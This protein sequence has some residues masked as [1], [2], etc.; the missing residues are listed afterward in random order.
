[1]L[2]L[3]RFMR[4]SLVAANAGYCLVV[5]LGLLFVVAYLVEHELQTHRL[6]WLWHLGLVAPWHGGSSQTRDQTPPPCTGRWICRWI[7]TEPPG[8]PC[9]CSVT[10]SYLTVWDPM[11]CSTPGFP[12][13]HQLLE[14]T[15]THVH[16]VGDA[17]QPSHSLLPASPPAFIL[18]QHQS[19]FHE[20][21][22]IRV[23]FHESSGSFSF[24]LGGQSIGA[25]TLASVLPMNIQC[26]FPLG[27]TGLISLQSK[28][29][30]R[31]FSSTIVWKHQF[32]GAQPS[33]SSNSHIHT[34]LLE[35]P[36]L[37]LYRLFSVRWCLCFLIC[38]LGLS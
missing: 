6:Q 14:L 7:P 29:L 3:H 12:V 31:I 20:S 8:K 2:G 16:W 36:L 22:S 17:I 24:A 32:F 37:W 35:K 11:N 23:F 38:C 18:S 9:C 19:L 1:M 5:V 13:H 27:L 4:F 25:L 15:Q 21:F 10:Q 30:S 26:W 28:G 33:L 34:W